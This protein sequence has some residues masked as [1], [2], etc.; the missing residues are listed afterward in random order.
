MEG[1]DGGITYDDAAVEA[2]LDRSQEGLTE[3]DSLVNEYL[4]SFK[5]AQYTIKPSVLAANG[6]GHA[7]VMTNALTAA[8]TDGAA[9]ATETD[10]LAENDPLFWEKL[11]G[12][13]FGRL[14]VVCS[15][16]KRYE[17]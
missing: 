6:S 9:V 5:V 10:D 3:K 12:D 4:S 13:D 17:I 7:E 8:T 15:V 16:T 11:L 14:K 1:A 2:L